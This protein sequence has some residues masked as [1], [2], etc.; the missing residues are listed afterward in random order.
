MFGKECSVVGA[1]E[2]WDCFQ[3][4]VLLLLLL[5]LSSGNGKLKRGLVRYEEVLTLCIAI[6]DCSLRKRTKRL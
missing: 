1:D 6:V 5:L 4:L 2:I 3:F